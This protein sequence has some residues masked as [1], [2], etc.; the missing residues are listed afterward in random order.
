ME[1]LGVF[2]Q[3]LDILGPA[4]AELRNRILTYNCETGHRSGS[5]RRNNY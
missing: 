4:G 5:E 1:L 2:Y 3:V